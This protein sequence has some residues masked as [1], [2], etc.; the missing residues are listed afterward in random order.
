MSGGHKSLFR[1][2]L[3]ADDRGPGRDRLRFMH[4]KTRP[5]AVL[6]IPSFSIKIFADANDFVDEVEVI[7]A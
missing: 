5:E 7:C 2:T 1:V 6:E 4:S 3:P